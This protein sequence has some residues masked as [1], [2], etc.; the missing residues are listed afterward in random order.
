MAIDTLR[1]RAS[2]ITVGLQPFNPADILPDGSLSSFDRQQLCWDY[3]GIAVGAG[4]EGGTNPS[5][6]PLVGVGV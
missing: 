2:V 6:L 1:K 4:S 3:R 5:K